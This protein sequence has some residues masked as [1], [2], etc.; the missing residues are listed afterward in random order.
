M[1]SGGSRE[2]I[3]GLDLL[4]AVAILLV[5]FEHSWRLLPSAPPSQRL[6]ALPGMW[7]VDLFFVL[8]G[9]LVGS[10]AIKAF[11]QAKVTWSMVVQFWRRRWYRTLPLYYLF[12]VLNISLLWIQGRP[13][14]SFPVSYVVFSQ[15]FGWEHPWFFG[16]AWSLAVEEWFYLL[17]P[18]L[19]IGF[20]FVFRSPKW[21]VVMTIVTIGMGCLLLRI[22][23]A[24]IY[25]EPTIRVW[26]HLFRVP[27]MLR[28]DAIA[29]GV[30]GAY[31]HRY[32]RSAWTSRPILFAA[33]GVALL[34]IHETWV[35]QIVLTG[36]AG[37]LAKTTYF[38]TA[39]LGLLLLFPLAIAFHSPHHVV[40]RVVTAVSLWSYALYL[41]HDSFLLDGL[42][43]RAPYWVE[44]TFAPEQVALVYVGYWT[45]CFLLAATVYRWYEKP[46]MDLRDRPSAWLPRAADR[47]VTDR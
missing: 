7:G 10:L 38:S 3:F 12:L 29:I 24:V 27:T 21:G 1:H 28:L 40:T 13:L 4:R 35:R 36:Q 15:S 41:I 42:I 8:S 39:G 44:S 45:A 32:Y 2:R 11:D 31:L 37:F 30:V 20:G 6:V 46:M 47:P 22:G 16:E 43:R 25:Q 33:I 18:I 26:S 9:F 23:W 34:V 17:L 5:L 14:D 19:I